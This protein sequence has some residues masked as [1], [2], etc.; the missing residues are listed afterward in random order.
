ML[1][2]LFNKG[3]PRKLNNASLSPLISEE[4]N[5]SRSGVD[6]STERFVP[7]RAEQPS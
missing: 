3:K 4:S 1:L 5:S 6:V 7:S 2:L